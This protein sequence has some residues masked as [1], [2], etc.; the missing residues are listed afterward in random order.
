MG[1]G[2]TRGADKLRWGEGWTG[3]QGTEVGFDM[4]EYS[5]EGHALGLNGDRTTLEQARG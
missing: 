3:V 2:Y 1:L 4:L 5:E